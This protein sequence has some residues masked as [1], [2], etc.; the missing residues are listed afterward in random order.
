[1]SLPV[2]PPFFPTR[3]TA[4][5]VDLPI[6]SH[7]FNLANF[8]I[9]YLNL[10]RF[11][12]FRDHKKAYLTHTNSTTKKIMWAE[13]VVPYYILIVLTVS[14]GVTKLPLILKTLSDDTEVGM[15]FSKAC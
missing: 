4:Y 6:I 1:M 14:S 5:R 2:E 9:S 8:E 7:I 11:A 3:Y 13:I 15:M 12:R 10:A